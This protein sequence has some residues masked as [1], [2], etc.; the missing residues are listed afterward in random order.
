MSDEAPAGLDPQTAAARLHAEGP[1]ELGV[2]QRRS[3][4]AIAWEVARAFGR[5]LPTIVVTRT[6]QDGLQHQLGYGS[7]ERLRATMALVRSG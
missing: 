3:L 5:K 6:P 4:R 1:N 2:S 7:P